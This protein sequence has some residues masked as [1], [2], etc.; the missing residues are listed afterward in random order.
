M[1]SK[2]LR[3][4]GFTL[5]ESLTALCLLGFILAI[6]L[7][8]FAQT[9][10]RYQSIKESSQA[11]QI[12][13]QCVQIHQQEDPE[14]QSVLVTHFIETYNH[15]HSVTV[16]DFACDDLSCQ[17]RFSSGEVLDVAIEKVIS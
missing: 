11:W 15:E 13:Y 9:F 16:Q 7:P 17:M 3:N 10:H 4:K 14:I 2:T 5:V 6:Y 1:F 8:A 12:F